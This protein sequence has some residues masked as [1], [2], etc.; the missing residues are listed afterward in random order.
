[1][2]AARLESV[3][4]FPWPI[5]PHERKDRTQSILPSRITAAGVTYY[6]MATDILSRQMAH[7][8]DAHFE[9]FRLASLIPKPLVLDH[10]GTR[11][12]S[13]PAASKR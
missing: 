4:Q 13:M 12:N 2:H 9:P 1:M 10:F 8:I 5:F 7:R 6:Q 11:V 3:R